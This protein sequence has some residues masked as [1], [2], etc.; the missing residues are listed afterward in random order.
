MAEFSKEPIN[1]SFLSNNK[2][3]FSI[4]RMPN[5]SFFVQEITL[6]DYSLSSTEIATPFTTIKSPGNQISFGELSVSFILDEDFQSWFDLYTWMSNLG[7]P[8]DFN[9]RGILTEVAGKLNSV[10]SDASLIIKTNSNNPNVII[11]FKDIYPTFISSLTFSSVQSQEFLTT[12]CSF[13]YTSYSAK[14]Y[15]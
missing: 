14:R 11:E 4:Q 1:K 9:K 2:F 6:P 12:T 5:L 15:S 7:N 10:T 3:E 8:D 13:A